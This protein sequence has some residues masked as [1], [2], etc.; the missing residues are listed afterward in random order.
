MFSLFNASLLSSAPV[1]VEG[2]VFPPNP[3]LPIVMDAVN[4]NGTE[5][6]LGGCKYHG[7]ND[8]RACSH[9]K[10][11]GVICSLGETV[12]HNLCVVYLYPEFYVSV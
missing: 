8:V 7:S 5:D 10:D 6:F 1:A 3:S 4:C 2:R 11:A 12:T 9:N